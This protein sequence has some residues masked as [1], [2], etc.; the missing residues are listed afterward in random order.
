M[1]ADAAVV[2][3]G[4][5]Q[6]R[7]RAK[8]L[9]DRG[10]ILVDGKPVKK[11]AQ[12]I[13]DEATLVC[14]GETLRYVG[15]GGLKLERA[16]AAFPIALEGAVCLD[17]GASTGGFTDCMLQ[18]GAKRVFAL[19]VGHGQ[20]APSLQNDTRVVNLEGTDIR[21]VTPEQLGGQVDFFTIDVSFISLT[22]VLPAAAA[23]LRDGGSAV[24]AGQAA[25]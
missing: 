2:Q 25:V 9:I 18:N 14:T 15:R 23:L 17:I 12:D 5:A 7:A 20:L 3:R 21:G 19:D 13:A 16:L 4:I 22:L 6:S 10:Q 11:A 1:R 24:V 8:E